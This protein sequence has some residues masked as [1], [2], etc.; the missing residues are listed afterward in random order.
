MATSCACICST[1]EDHMSQCSKVATT[2]RE[3]V[4]RVKLDMC[5]PCANAWDRRKAAVRA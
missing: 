5:E 1:Y 2:E 4:M 3:A